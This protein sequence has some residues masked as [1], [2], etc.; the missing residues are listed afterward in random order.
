MDNT[1]PLVLIDDDEDDLFLIKSILSDLDNH[2]PVRTFN[3]GSDAFEYLCSAREQPALI[4]SD[5]NMPVMTGLELCE[6]I[7]SDEA[8]S[9]KEIPIVLWSTSVDN[10]HSDVKEN[11]NVKGIF[12]KGDN[13]AELKSTMANILEYLQ[14]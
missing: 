8:L 12:K 1:S 11:A 9:K 7:S 3:N 6:N 4:L 2:I 13:Y 14:F 5:I 10:L